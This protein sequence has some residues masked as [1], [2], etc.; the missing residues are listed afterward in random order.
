MSPQRRLTPVAAVRGSADA[1]ID[2]VVAIGIAGPR[3]QVEAASCARGRLGGVPQ[4]PPA[5]EA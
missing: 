2:A 1:T 5:Q 4:A 3:R